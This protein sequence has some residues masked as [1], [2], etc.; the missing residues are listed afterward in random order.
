MLQFE[1]LKTS[2]IAALQAHDLPKHISALDASLA[3]KLNEGDADDLE[4]Q[5]KVAYTLTSASKAKAN[6]QF[7][8]PDFAQGNEVQNVLIK[9]K[10]ADD[11][12]PFKPGE[13]VTR[14]AQAS[15]R[16][17]TSDKH[18]RAWKLYKV[19]PLTS[20][21]NPATTNKDFCLY[22]PPYKSYTYS[23]AWVHFL[24]EEVADDERWTSL[25]TFAN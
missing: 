25:S 9:F 21:G 14:V 6:L 4:Y 22:H 2:E 18:Q 24:I 17:F 3:A 12:W 15:G 13:V 10:P 11:I 8:Q 19:R 16:S 5:F 1:R 7:V 23:Q 20:A